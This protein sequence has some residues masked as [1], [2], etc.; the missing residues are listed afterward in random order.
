[1]NDLCAHHDL[2]REDLNLHLGPLG[3][4]LAENPW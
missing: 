1:M 2:R 4:L 3:P